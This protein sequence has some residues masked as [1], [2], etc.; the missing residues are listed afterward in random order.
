MQQ[1][2]RDAESKSY[3][4]TPGNAGQVSQLIRE[5]KSRLEIVVYPWG[6]D[7]VV[8]SPPALTC[9]VTEGEGIEV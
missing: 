6:V 4:L 9:C 5:G 8:S 7:F 3:E 2:T 1:Q